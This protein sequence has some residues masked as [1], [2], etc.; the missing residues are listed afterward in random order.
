[1]LSIDGRAMTR[2]VLLHGNA[3]LHVLEP[4]EDDLDPG[5]SALLV[6]RGGDDSQELAVRCHV[7]HPRLQR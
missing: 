6:R 4:V 3:P 7:V 2:R 1:M 5:W